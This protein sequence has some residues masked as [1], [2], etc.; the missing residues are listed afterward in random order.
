M[1]WVIDIRS[2]PGGVVVVSSSGSVLS[3]SPCT[4]GARTCCNKQVRV[5]VWREIRSEM[6]ATSVQA[7]AA[8]LC[9]VVLA[10]SPR[11]ALGNCRNDCNAAC[12]GWPV[13]C[14]LSCASACMGEVG[15]STLSTTAAAPAK[16]PASAPAQ[17]G[18]GVSV[19]RGLKPSSAAHGDGDAPTN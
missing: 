10:A 9:L 16:D 15:I 12:N 19:L 7:A 13:V 14:Q 2:R 3:S 4:R 1:A 18:G 5:A 17:Q 11:A 8:V 6:A